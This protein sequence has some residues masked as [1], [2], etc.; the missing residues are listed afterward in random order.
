VR[1]V[2]DIARAP[3]A[4]APIDVTL[5]NTV[6]SAMNALVEAGGLPR[7]VRLIN[8]AG[9]PLK[10]TLV[11]RLL[12]MTE[13]HTVCNLYGPSETTTYST[14]VAMRRGEP[15][16]PHIGRPITN[17]R[18]YILD[19]HGE[20]VPVGVTGELYIGGEGVARGY[21]NRPELTAERFLTDPF[22][23]ESGARMY[24]T[25]DLGRWLADGT[26]EYLGRND[27]QVKVRGFRIELGE[28]EATLGSH[29]GVREAVVV[30][31]EDVPG[32]KRLVAY[33]TASE[34]NGRA[35]GAEKLRSHLSSR[36]PE[37]MVPAAFVRVDRMPLLENGKLDRKALPVPVGDA[38]GIRGYESP[39]GE[40]EKRLAGILADVLKVERVGRHYNF[41]ELGG[42]SL[43]AMQV[44][45]RICREFDV[46]LSVRTIFEQPTIAGLGIEVEK[47]RAT[48]IKSRTP[49]L[50]RRPRPA[51]PNVSR[52]ALLAQLD[53]LSGDD[54]QTLLKDFDA[55]L[56]P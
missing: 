2:L 29:P 15:F 45:A 18:I 13:V 42:H 37:Y 20:A 22:V 16:A 12:A 47:A 48:G 39:Q 10:R 7:S 31:R 24:R 28:I 14:W 34:A 51:A 6:P 41:F 3:V 46:E 40:I 26:I 43:L 36:L 1:D 56:L 49:V 33:Y 54:V 21:L 8:L 9:E 32:E 35:S 17:T 4:R 25:G 11:E 27:D 53:T 5:I 38:Y 55:R 52:E 19:I 30:V 50:E 44:M 23:G